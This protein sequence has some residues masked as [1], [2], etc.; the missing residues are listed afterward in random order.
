MRIDTIQ[1]Y[2]SG[3]KS[4][5]SENSV[6]D[7]PLRSM[8]HETPVAVIRRWILLHS[9]D[10]ITMAVFAG[11][12]LG[13]N[14]AP[15]VHSR[16]FPIY[17]QNGNVAHPQFAYPFH[18]NIIKIWVDVF[19][20]FFTPLV[21]ITLFQ[22]R[23][24]SLEDWLTTNLGVIKSLLTSSVFQ[25]II[26]VIIGGFRPHFLDI[27][28]PSIQPDSAPSGTGFAGLMYDD[29]VCTGTDHKRIGNA[30]ESM[31]SGHSA[32]AWAGLFYLALYFNAQ[33]KVMAAH[34]PAYWKMI[35][36]FAP[37]LGACLIS[38]AMTIDY[39]HHWYDV[40]AGALIGITTA[41]IAFRQT[42]ASVTDFRY[43]HILLPRSTS[44]FHRQAYL[45]HGGSKG[46]FCPYQ[47]SAADE[48]ASYNLPVTREGGWGY[49]EE[50]S[51]GV[52]DGEAQYAGAPWDASSFIVNVNR[53]TLTGG[54]GTS[55]RGAHN[56]SRMPEVEDSHN[57]SQT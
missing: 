23:R 13:S 2:I 6:D 57:Y 3:D 56:R 20:A 42:F 14:S 40:V 29:K 34:N 52:S 39:S 35:L 16:S 41:I 1:A 46:P 4:H 30:M 18:E 43:N 15:P 38:G 12:A 51:R 21:F 50:R 37:I 11:V 26:K 22:I 54:T 9:A 25:V 49:S 36:F 8:R 55:F 47:V 17:F 7:T 28:K 48:L 27:C 45:R 10:L 32:A 31:P 33:L 5:M 44:L 19:I 53:V 24:R